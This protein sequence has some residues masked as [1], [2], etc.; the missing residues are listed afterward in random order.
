MLRKVSLN[1]LSRYLTDASQV[2]VRT[3]FNVPIRDGKILD[4]TRIEGTIPTLRHL[5]RHNPKSI[6]L[7]SHMGRPNG[8]PNSKFSLRPV[9]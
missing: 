3:D 8:Q 6:V 4:L 7:L 1:L 2:V 9:V 5:I